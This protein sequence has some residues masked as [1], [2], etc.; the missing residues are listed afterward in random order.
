MQMDSGHNSYLKDSLPVGPDCFQNKTQVQAVQ[1]ME[2][3]I[4][5]LHKS[6]GLG[7]GITTVPLDIWKNE[8][9]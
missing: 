2:I 7:E 6:F 3:S 9:A 8:S 1:G 5:P 4:Y